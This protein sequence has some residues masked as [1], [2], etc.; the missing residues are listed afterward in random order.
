MKKNILT[1]LLFLSFINLFAQEADFKVIQNKGGKTI[2]YAPNSGVK[3]L[4]INGLAFKDLNKN[5]K[6]DKYE[7]W[8]LSDNIRSKD[9]ASKLSIEQIA[10]LML[11]SSHQSI[12]ARAGGYFAGTYGGKSFKAGEI[13]PSELT[14]QQ[15]KFLE[16]D[17]LRHVLLTTVQTP[18]IAAKWNNKM[19]AF[20]ESIGLGI[21][22]NNSSDPRHATSAKAEY[23]AASGGEI[24]MWP[25]SLG[26]A[27]TFDP[28]LTE[29]FGK[30]AAA[31]YRALG[32]TT[33][34][35]PQVDIATE[36]R[37]AVLMVLLAKVRGFRRLWHKLIAMVFNLLFG[38]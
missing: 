22:A 9:L 4:T 28:T 8:R 29:K 21:P 35:S 3:V 26:M 2:G 13:D 18:E 10:G 7:D 16:E 37:W 30:I 6:L 31:E 19:Q 33:A 14:D 23:D 24:S 38:E 32:I 12:P 34:L 1:T 25:S 15:K 5:S 27:S 36:P 20:C 17:N 11:Y